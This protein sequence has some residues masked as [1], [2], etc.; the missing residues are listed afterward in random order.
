M[1]TKCAK[2]A[3][4]NK[5]QPPGTVL[6]PFTSDQP[7]QPNASP[8]NEEERLAKEYQEMCRNERLVAFSN[9]SLSN[10]GQEVDVEALVEDAEENIKGFLDITFQI[11]DNYDSEL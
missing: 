5:N 6:V 11:L 3:P 9:W 2:N 1:M 8:I 10:S 7:A 4:S